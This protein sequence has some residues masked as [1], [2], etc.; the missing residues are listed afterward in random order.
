MVRLALQAASSFLN[1]DM[2]RLGW[3]GL[4][5]MPDKESAPGTE[6]SAEY[7]MARKIFWFVLGSSTVTLSFGAIAW[8]VMR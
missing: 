5:D 2:M 1:W 8:W 3:W 4:A 6:R 7:Q